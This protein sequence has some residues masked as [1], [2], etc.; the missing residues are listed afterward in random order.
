MVRRMLVQQAMVEIEQAPDEEWKRKLSVTFIGEEGLD[1]GGLTREFFTI[2]YE[3]SPVFENSVFS[4]DAQLLD[5]RHYFL[6]GQM[7]VMGILSGHP[8]PR[9]LMKHIV[10]FIVSGKTGELS[11]IPVDK[12]ERMDAVSAIKEVFSF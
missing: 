2:L 4:F 11:N 3:K 9:N 5:K 1:S 7:V 6:M 10:D 12:I 8:G